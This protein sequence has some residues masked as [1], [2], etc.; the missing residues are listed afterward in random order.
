[1]SDASHPLHIGDRVR[2]FVRHVLHPGAEQVLMALHANDEIEGTLIA[3]SIHSGTQGT[4]GAIE[5]TGVAGHCVVAEAD[6]R[7]VSDE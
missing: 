3:A 4:F 7:A 2:F 1:M 5:V 6:I